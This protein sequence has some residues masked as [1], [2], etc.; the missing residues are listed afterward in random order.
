MNKII[1][2]EEFSV[3]NA[4]VDQEHQELIETINA[5]FDV[6]G[7]ESEKDPVVDGLGEI[8]TM[9]ASHFALEEKIMLDVRYGQYPAH[10]EDHEVLL[11]EL[12]EI[13]DTVELGDSFD[14]ADLTTTL[15]RW[16]SEHFS[17]HD[18]RLHGKL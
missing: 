15:N 17:T 1:W 6:I 11:D 5:L 9:I 14:E 10:K 7:A 13:I 18:A 4:A 16:F 12:S 3:G 2:R 8:Y